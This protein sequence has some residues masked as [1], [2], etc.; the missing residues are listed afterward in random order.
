[1]FRKQFSAF[2][3]R[4]QHIK[5]N[6]EKEEKQRVNVKKEENKLQFKVFSDEQSKPFLSSLSLSDFQLRIALP[7]LNVGSEKRKMVK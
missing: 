3:S 6:F 5:V 4:S 1:M 7:A 2:F